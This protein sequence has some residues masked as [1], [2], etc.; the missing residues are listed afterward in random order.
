M[1]VAKIEHL[2]AWC[3]NPIPATGDN[4]LAIDTQAVHRARIVL[5]WHFEADA[6]CADADELYQQIADSLSLPDADP[7]G[8]RVFS[9]AFR[10]LHAR[11]QA[12]GAD[13]LRGVFDIR[14]D[15]ATG[16]YTLRGAGHRWG[17]VSLRGAK[18]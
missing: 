5:R 12:A 9:K 13:K 1:S 15:F 18:K 8:S 17:A 16:R 4:V 7:D 10:A 3:L 2:C 14:A 11:T 6:A